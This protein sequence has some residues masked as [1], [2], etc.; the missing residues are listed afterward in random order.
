MINY[1][2]SFKYA[3]YGSVLGFVVL[4]LLLFSGNSPW[5]SASWMGAWIPGITAY[6]AMKTYALEEQESQVLY[7]AVLKRSMLV[8]LFQAFFYNLM[9]AVFVY[10]FSVDAVDLYQTEMM[11]NAA[12]LKT[13]V[14]AEMY[15]QIILELEKITFTTLAFWDFIYK[16]I[17]GFMVSLILA[18]I[19]KKNKP[20]F[21]NE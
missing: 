8:I 18:A 11:Q 19:F 20:I 12:Q 16:L 7:G 4:L 21:D 6:F 15:D 1:N 3:L 10:L 2:L 13:M 5:S 17:G 14:G 9:A